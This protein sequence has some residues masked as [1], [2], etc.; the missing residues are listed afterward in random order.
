MDKNE[1]Y[2]MCMH[3]KL[4]P[5]VHPQVINN[6]ETD[7]TTRNVT[8]LHSFGGPATPQASG[9]NGRSETEEDGKEQTQYSREC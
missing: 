4:L 8:M 9:R 6:K 1:N 7:V 5:A 3:L 2:K